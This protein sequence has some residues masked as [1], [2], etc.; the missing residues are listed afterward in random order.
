MVF[1]YDIGHRLPS[2]SVRTYVR[3]AFPRSLLLRSEIHA[4]AMKC[5]DIRQVRRVLNNEKSDVFGGP[6]AGSEVRNAECMIGGK[7]LHN[8]LRSV[9]THNARSDI[10]QHSS[11]DT[12]LHGCSVSLHREIEAILSPFHLCQDHKPM[13]HPNLQRICFRPR[14]GTHNHRRHKMYKNSHISSFRVKQRSLE[15]DYRQIDH[16]IN[17]TY[18]SANPKQ[19]SSVSRVSSIQ[20]INSPL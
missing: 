9:H 11:R 12:P 20:N 19:K 2:P 4:P 13:N 16:M 14:Y 10:R 5:I 7:R 3:F 15:N 8:L 18:R 6:E 17:P 1:L